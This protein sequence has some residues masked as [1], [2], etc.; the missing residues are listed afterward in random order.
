MKT[1]TRK[2]KMETITACVQHISVLESKAIEIYGSSFAALKEMA[3]F[4][5]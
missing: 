1:G 3:K 2:T 5:K 4:E